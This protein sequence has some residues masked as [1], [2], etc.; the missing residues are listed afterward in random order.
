MWCNYIH[1][2]L[3]VAEDQ[4]GLSEK[5]NPLDYLIEKPSAQTKYSKTS[6]SGIP[7]VAQWK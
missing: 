2:N 6:L 4:I 3:L 7:V 5:M 1:Q